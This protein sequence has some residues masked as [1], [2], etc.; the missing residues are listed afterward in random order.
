MLLLLLQL[1][2]V[3][4]RAQEKE[5]AVR[6][7]LRQADTRLEE[8]DYRAALR[9]YQRVLRR[10]ARSVPALIG[11]GRTMMELPAGG[12]R[13]LEYL[14]RAVRL[15]PREP[16][17]HYY[18][19]LAHIRLSGS[20]LGRDNAKLGLDEL[21]R[22][23]E[24]D[25]SHPDAYYRKG[26]LLR[27]EYRDYNGAADAFLLQL[28][29][30]PQ[31]MEARQQLL[32]VY[33]LAGN[34]R[35]AVRVGEEIVARAP[36]SQE[37]YPYLAAAQWYLGMTGEAIET[38]NRYFKV[39]EE[40]ER[41]LY[42]DLVHILTPGEQAEFAALDEAGKRH[43]RDRYWKV[44]DPDPRTPRNERLLEHYIR[45]AYSRIEF[46]RKTWPWDDRGSVYV[47]Y[48]EP[49]V[50]VGWG[51]PYA[52][53]LLEDPVLS[54][55][56]RDFEKSL[57]LPY[58]TDRLSEASRARASR[59]PERWLY[60][61]RGIDL[62]FHDPVMGGRFLVQGNRNRL[63]IDRMEEKLPT[64]SVEEDRIARITP[65]QSVVTFRGQ[66]G[67]TAVEYAF[68]L[69]PDEFGVFRSPTGA[70]AQL[71][72][73][74]QLYTPDWKPVAGAA[75]TDR[76]VETVPQIRIRG[77]PLFVD[78]S[79]LEAE[80]GAY[81]LTTM[82]LDP[83]TGA[84]AIAE[85]T[86]ALP[87]YSGTDLMISDILPAARVREVGRG[88]VG[89]FIRGELEVLPL[90]GGILQANQSLFIYYEI[91]NLTKDDIG[92]T[93][94]EVKYAVFE[95]V[96]EVGL[97]G[98]I[99]RGV[100]NLFRRGDSLAGLSSTIRSSGIRFDEPSYLELDMSL[101]PPGTYELQLVVTDRLG[102]GST[103]NALRFRT[104]PER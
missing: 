92:A 66:D 69:L 95:V 19:A 48:G 3:S 4:A 60:L 45:V 32:E 1:L 8:E 58:A 84:R 103:S 11:L 59:D 87:D 55:R 26:A 102:G 79:R 38:F 49:D 37:A 56:R 5:A 20:D 47:R 10:E 74:V 52:E 17:P 6:S 82:L 13:A 18:K 21:E 75:E 81:I 63:L 68:A 77:I 83:G 40:R 25:P 70:Y 85:E 101:A 90:P 42:F 71:D 46:G 53:E 7:L 12:I 9:L 80:P 86:I 24:L 104:L 78:A 72:I 76:R 50:R 28:E 54:S 41:S 61:D 44:R 39:A 64:L 73:G 57:G 91:Y 33:V 51:R 14:S 89:R 23:I 65:L 29:A 88:R 16:G 94:Y 43:Y 2:P 99:F 62:S 98:R 22:T 36:A 93:D 96:E 31:H 27:E 100:R 34:W 35:E 67:R 15:A 97:T 30:N